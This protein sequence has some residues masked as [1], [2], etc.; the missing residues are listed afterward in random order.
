[1]SRALSSADRVKPQS[2]SSVA[3]EYYDAERHPTCRNF[4]DASRSLLRDALCIIPR[5]GSALEVGA[6][7]ALLGELAPKG[8]DR[9]ILLDKSEEMISYSRGFN[10]I[11]D[12]V[13]GDALSLPF[14]GN[15]FSLIVA[16]LA[17]PF[18][19]PR[20]WNEVR[21]TLKLG[22]YC[23]FTTPSYEWASSF[24]MRSA[25]E[26][27]GAAFFQTREGE[28]IY[29]PSFVEPEAS[30]RKMIESAGLHLLQITSIGTAAIPEPHS[31]KIRGCE[32]VVSGYIV[33]RT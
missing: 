8:F 10:Q 3:A 27:Q 5:S 29:L 20:F 32:S 24:R 9:L 25:Y 21:R 12:L 30:Q 13:V 17:D 31:P 28:R 18:N 33:Q 26:Q 1:M 14:E 6:G 22:A 11:A 2:Y 19:G 7:R 15:T 4:R 16:S 23:V